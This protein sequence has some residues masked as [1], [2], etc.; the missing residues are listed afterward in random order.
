LLFIICCQQL[1][2]TMKCLDSGFSCHSKHTCSNFQPRLCDRE[3][4]TLQTDRQTDR[5]HYTMHC[6][7]KCMA[8]LLRDL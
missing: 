3:Q 1:K 2:Q 4:P 7:E 5:G 6:M 8:I